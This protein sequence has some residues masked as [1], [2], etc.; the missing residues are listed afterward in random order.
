MGWPC[1]DECM[2]RSRLLPCYKNTFILL[3]LTRIANSGQEESYVC[4]VES[5]AL[6]WAPI[7]TQASSRGGDPGS[8]NFWP[9]FFLKISGHETGPSSLKLTDKKGKQQFPSGSG[10]LGQLWG[11]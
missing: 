3:S 7:S 1:P 5:V 8:V 11:E 4:G 6:R 10:D 9:G 2:P